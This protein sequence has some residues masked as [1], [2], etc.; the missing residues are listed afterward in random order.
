MQDEFALLQSDFTREVFCYSGSLPTIDLTIRYLLSDKPTASARAIRAE[1]DRPPYK[2]RSKSGSAQ[3][4]AILSKIEGSKEAR[5][6][7]ETARIGAGIA[8]RLTLA[9]ARG[10]AP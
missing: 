10:G 8:R 5:K 3:A 1:G 2:G 4:R 6:T 7:G 9:R